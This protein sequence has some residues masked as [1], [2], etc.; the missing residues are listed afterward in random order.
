[1]LAVMTYSAELLIMTIAG[2]ATGYAV[3]FNIEDDL[4][5]T[6][7]TT[8]PCCNFMMDEAKEGTHGVA[9]TAANSDAPYGSSIHECCGSGDDVAGVG[10]GGPL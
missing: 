2:L 8:N 3:F 9:G 6:H 10:E 1:M 4:D 5:G 7:V